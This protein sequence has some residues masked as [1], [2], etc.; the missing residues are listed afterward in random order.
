MH[1]RH[2]YGDDPFAPHTG[3]KLGEQMVLFLCSNSFA[4]EY[5]HFLTRTKVFISETYLEQLSCSLKRYVLS[6]RIRSLDDD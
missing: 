2:I 4:K 3:V 6:S 1:F 5:T